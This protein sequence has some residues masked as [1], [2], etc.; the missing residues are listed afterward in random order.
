MAAIASMTLQL[1]SPQPMGTFVS[2]RIY[3]EKNQVGHLWVRCLAL[4][5]TA[6]RTGGRLNEASP[7][8][9]GNCV[10]ENL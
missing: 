3:K 7:N 8:F 4:G 1:G 5:Q 2:L 6:K 9:R 10:G